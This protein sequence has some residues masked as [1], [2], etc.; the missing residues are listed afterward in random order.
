M[1]EVGKPEVG[2]VVLNW[3][4]ADDTLA[5]LRSLRESTVRVH[6][7]V[8]DNGST[9]GSGEAISASG[10]ADDVVMTGENLGYAEGNNAG[11]RLLLD[12]GFE[13]VTVLNNDT[14]VEPSA[15]E[16]LS[17][18]LRSTERR[19]ISPVIGYLS[20]GDGAW[21][22][23]GVI[24]RGWPRHLQ[25]DET[26][27]SDEALRSTEILT[28]CCIA[29]RREVWNR[30]GLFD[31]AYFLTFEDSDWCMRAA[32][33][34]TALYVASE[35]RIRHHVSR[36]FQAPP[37][38]LLGAFYFVRNGLRFESRYFARH[39][40]RF[41]YRWVV[42]PTPSLVRSRRG[43]E[44]GFRWLGLCAFMVGQRGRAPVVVEQ[45]ARRLSG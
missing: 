9:D 37:V 20:E 17:A 12:A 44:A 13:I 24:D 11:L 42:R 16:V 36:S 25:R 4:G 6:V 31:P 23:G 30:V 29:A 27:A 22:E 7:T 41:V 40:M 28:G 38:S 14:I 8:V 26:V 33:S 32:A 39:L 18:R 5:C 10:L 43:S 15:L 34:G 3:N 35:S 19:A 21:F 2:V 45:L 1:N